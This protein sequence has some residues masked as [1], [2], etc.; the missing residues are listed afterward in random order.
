MDRQLINSSHIKSFQED[1][2]VLVKGLFKDFVDII[3]D[4]INYNIKN[5]GPYSAENLHAGESG[6]FFDDYCNW[7][8]IPQF[9]DVIFQSRVGEVAAA[10]MSSKKVQL[11]HDHVLVKEPGTSKPTPWHQDEP[12]WSVDGYNTC[13][14]WMPLVPVKK[15]NA[16]AFVPG[17]HRFDSTFY[18]FNFGSLNPDEIEDI[19]ETNFEGI[20]DVEFPDI[21]ADPEK[22]GVVSWDMNP[23]DCIAFNSRIMHGG[24]GKLDEE[25][26]LRVFTSKWIGDDVF[27]KFRECGMDPDHS[28][29]MTKQGLKPGDRPGTE[30]YPSIPLSSPG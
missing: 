4:G 13:T 21:A 5:P 14:I 23:G 7:S 19:D 2:V 12:Y 9:K 3:R 26:E 25:T 10:L 22:Y 6:R 30:L 18:Q 15:E 16:L 17:S 8:R 27:I 20:T 28:E 11:F 29:V 24:S 1:G